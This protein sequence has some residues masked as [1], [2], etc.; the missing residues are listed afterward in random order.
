MKKLTTSSRDKIHS[1][2]DKRTSINSETGC[3]E[4]KGV[5]SDGY[6]QI[7][8]DGEFYYVH[9]LSA[10]VNFNYIPTNGLM[11]CHKDICKAKN[12]WN[13]EHI[14]IGDAA[15]NNEDMKR[16]G[17]AKGK[18]SDMTHCVNGHE[19]DFNNTY[20]SRRKETGEMRR[21]CRVCNNMRTKEYRQQLKLAKIS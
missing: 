12:C 1:I 18:Y 20:W 10:M 4:Y 21:H 16:A 17:N 8:I 3:W 19:F 15:E 13:P 5:N 6:G 14:Y 2:L 11:I 7:T 9:V